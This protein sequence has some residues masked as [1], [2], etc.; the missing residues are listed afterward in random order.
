MFRSSVTLCKVTLTPKDF[1]GYENRVN[2]FIS[3]TGSGINVSIISFIY[4][5]TNCN[6]GPLKTEILILMKSSVS[7]ILKIPLMRDQLAMCA[8][9]GE[10]THAR[11]HTRTHAH[12]F[13]LI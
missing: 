12:I 1:C 10:H 7:R 4:F 5:M 3:G 8:M 2:I 9:P 11:M 13:S 6:V